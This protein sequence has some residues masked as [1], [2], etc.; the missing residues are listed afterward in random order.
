MSSEKPFAMDGNATDTADNATNAA[1]NATDAA[2]PQRQLHATE[3]SSASA[4][5]EPTGLQASP[6]TGA[7][8]HSLAPLV[9]PAAADIDAQR[10]LEAEIKPPRSLHRLARNALNEISRAGVN[11]DIDQNLERWFPWRR[12][13][14][15]HKHAYD[16]VGTGVTHAIAEYI[17]D[18]RDANRGY[19][20]RLDFVIYRTD[21]TSCRLHPGT[22]RRNDAKLIFN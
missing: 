22:K 19:Q 20:K 14:A 5:P 21:G 12:Y 13:I 7:T 16:I 10:A 6:Q 11:S 2:S 15:C 1:D 8:E 3:Q 4:E 9:L 18:T 17:P